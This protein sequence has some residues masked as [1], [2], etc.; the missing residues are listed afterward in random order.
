M[1]NKKDKKTRRNNQEER[2]EQNQ[3]EG[4]EETKK[5]QNGSKTKQVSSMIGSSD[6][7]IVM[8]NILYSLQTRLDYME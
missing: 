2:Q 8:Y 3:G 6:S 1:K 5:Q 7:K 4:Q